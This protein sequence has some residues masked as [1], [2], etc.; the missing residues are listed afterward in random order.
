ML[1]IFDRGVFELAW[2]DRKQM[3]RLNDRHCGDLGADLLGEEEALIDGLRGEV[4]P[5]VGIRIF[6]NKCGSPP[7]SVS[8][9]QRIKY[10]FSTDSVRYP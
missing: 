9:T 7:L 10:S 6:L 5:V 4:R 8:S 3:E 1:L 2:R